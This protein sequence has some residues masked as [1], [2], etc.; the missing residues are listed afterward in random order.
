[1]SNDCFRIKG[2]VLTTLILELDQYDSEQFKQQLSKKIESSPDFFKQSPIVI[3][4]KKI[5]TD[6]PPVNYAEILSICNELNL[7]PVAFKAS[8]Q[9]DTIE[10]KKTGLG[11]ITD[12]ACGKSKPQES[13]KSSEQT[14]EALIISKPVRSGQQVYAEGKDLIILGSV[15]GGAEVLA[16]GNIHIY[17]SLRGRALAGVSGNTTARIFCTSHE[18]ELVSIAGQFLHSD[19][20]E[21][22]LWKKP[23]QCYLEDETLHVSS[24]S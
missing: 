14:P 18:A 1:M 19:S 16:D 3:D 12:R 5:D 10:I 13:S 11:I 8:P 15:S 17:G 22:D 6:K 20:L 2:S 4:L 7:V 23:V 24:L 9:L 21:T